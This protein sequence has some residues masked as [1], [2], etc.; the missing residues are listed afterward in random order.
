[1]GY[2]GA[3][4]SKPD[5]YGSAPEFLCFLEKNVLEN[6]APT[7]TRTADL[8]ITNPLLYQLSYRGTGGSFI[9]LVHKAQA[10]MTRS[11]SCHISSRSGHDF[12]AASAFLLPMQDGS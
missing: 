5:L 1:M 12:A 4:A 3:E 10:V 9:V 11:C 7:R 6:G 8:R 2:H